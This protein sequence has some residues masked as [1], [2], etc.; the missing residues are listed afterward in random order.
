[1]Q[2]YKTTTTIDKNLCYTSLLRNLPHLLHFDFR[3]AKIT[4]DPEEIINHFLY[5][6]RPTT[7]HPILMPSRNIYEGEYINYCK[8]HNVEMVLE[9]QISTE[10]SEN[11]YKSMIDDLLINFGR[12]ITKT[13]VNINIGKFQK[14]DTTAIYPTFDNIY[15]KT[16]CQIKTTEN[17]TENLISLGDD[18]VLKFTNEKKITNNFYNKLP[19]ASQIFNTNRIVLHEKMIEIQEQNNNELKLLQVKTDSITFADTIKIKN[20]SK[21]NNDLDGWK[22]ETYK[23]VEFNGIY[24]GCINMLFDNINPINLKNDRTIY[25]CYA[26]AGKTYTIINDILPQVNE[27]YIILTP[28]HASMKEFKQKKMNC[29]II[30]RF[31]VGFYKGQLPLQNNIIID[32]HSMLDRSAHDFIYKCVLSNKN[33]YMFGDFNQFAPVEPANK[34][35]YKKY[36]NEYYINMLFNK[37]LK[38]TNN[39]RNDF[40]KEYYDSLI[41]CPDDNIKYLT[42]EV[43][44]YSTKTYKNADVIITYTNDTLDLYNQMKMK[45]L[46]LSKYSPGLK[47]ICNTNDLMKH[48]L[49][50]NFETVILKT[51]EEN[52]YIT[53]VEDEELKILKID[54][55]AYFKPAYAKTLY[56]CQGQS[57]KKIFYAPEDYK[58][59]NNTSAYVFISRL[60]TK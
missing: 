7:P 58:Y 36:N 22:Y 39:Y 31:T 24:D 46:N 9:F 42:K 15:N 11:Y 51:D 60:L 40:T 17:M 37:Q 23:P 33:I 57:I 5:I 41:N 1:V 44:K 45:D 35:K 55:D 2:K 59:I 54:Y 43:K 18:Y 14:N 21:D 12:D 34:S 38:L 16:E 8:L 20:V 49:Y 10:K 6:A 29:S 50:N 48:G 56:K 52:I 27:D 25:N 32:E 4:Q 30:H 19:I 13:M 3:T 26:G 47:V 53:G 28:T